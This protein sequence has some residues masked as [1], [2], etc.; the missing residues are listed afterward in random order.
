[1]FGR[2][3]AGVQRV[4]LVALIAIW[5]PVVVAIGLGLEANRQIGTSISTAT[6][7]VTDAVDSV[8]TIANYSYSQ[9]LRLKSGPY[10]RARARAHRLHTDPT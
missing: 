10:V 5:V 6:G 9:I 4:L 7:Y 2:Y 3:S 8:N 1:M